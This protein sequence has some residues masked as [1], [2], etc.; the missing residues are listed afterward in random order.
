MLNVCAGSP[1][2]ALFLIC[3]SSLSLKLALLTMC[4]G[5]PAADFLCVAEFFSLASPLALPRHSGEPSSVSA[6]TSVDRPRPKG[7]KQ[8]E[9]GLFM[10]PARDLWVFFFCLFCFS[11]ISPANSRKARVTCRGRPRRPR[12]IEIYSRILSYFVSQHEPTAD[13]HQQ[14]HTPPTNTT[15]SETAVIP[16]V[17]LFFALLLYT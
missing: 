17:L 10:P 1:T 5:A 6:E 7:K 3:W 13:R 16:R 12:C 15:G 11:P 9:V 2:N 8:R 14:A 4:C